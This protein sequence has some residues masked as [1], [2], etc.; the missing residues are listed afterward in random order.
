[1][2]EGWEHEVYFLFFDDDESHRLTVSYGIQSHLPGYQLL[3][4]RSWDD[5]IVADEDGQLFTVPCVPL[6]E[7]YVSRCAHLP[8]PASL[9]PDERFAGRIKWYVTPIIFGGDPQLGDNVI[10][11]PLEKHVELVIWWNARYYEAKAT[12]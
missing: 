4:L 1:M 10:W 5:F 2:T 8:Q 7:Q 6:A 11:V 3:G 12:S 9:V